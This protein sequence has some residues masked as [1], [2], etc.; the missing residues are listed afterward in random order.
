MVRKPQDALTIVPSAGNFPL[1]YSTLGFGSPIAGRVHL[2]SLMEYNSSPCVRRIYRIVQ[3]GPRQN[4]G[5]KMHTKD[6]QS[7]CWIKGSTSLIELLT[8]HMTRKY[9]KS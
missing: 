5:D 3:L 9:R 8:T 7:L 6:C 2:Y 4:S 1:F